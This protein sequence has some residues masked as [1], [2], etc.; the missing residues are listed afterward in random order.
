MT[1]DSGHEAGE[2]SRRGSR[3]SLAHKL[4]INSLSQGLRQVVQAVGGLAS[5]AIVSR[6]L[7][8]DEYGAVLAA[9]A[10]VSVFSLAG[11]FGIT[12]TTARL[13]AREPERRDELAT[14]SLYAWIAFAALAAGAI[15]GLAQVVYPGAERALI[16]HAAM[17]LVIPMA[18]TPLGGMA[19]AIAI[20]EQRAWLLAVGAVLSRVASLGAIV[21]A[22]SLGYGPIGI[23]AAFASGIA[24]DALFPF[25]L[26]RPRMPVRGSPRRIAATI[27]RL[28]GIAAPLG[29]IVVL[30]GLYF[31]LDALLLSLLGSTRD[32]AL[33]GVAYKGYDMLLV[34]PGFVMVTLLPVLA[35]LAPG[36][37][38]FR[39]IVQKAFAGMC[40]LVAPV[41]ALALLGREI[42]VALGGS[43]YAGGGLVL[44]LVL[45]GVLIACL[46][47]TLVQVMVA[48]GRQ[49][50]VLRVTA[51]TLCVNAIANVV[52]IPLWGVRGSAS[53]LLLSEAVSLAGTLL[54]YRT[55]APL[56]RVPAP[57]RLVAA[58]GCMAAAMSVRYV[59]SGGDGVRL[60]VGVAAGSVAYVAALVALRAVPPYVGDLVRGIAAAARGRV[61]S[62][63]GRPLR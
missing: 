35:R 25:L 11:D 5:V 8:I 32:V 58:V 63:R 18:L 29:A 10:F 27:R 47:G 2:A 28:V 13:M 62:P 56:P 57:A 46:N 1:T 38:R 20:V 61:R 44:A 24:F 17:V 52:A 15:A 19:G 12:V 49:R 36:D 60:L 30:N 4:A 33:Y 7:A 41:A 3:L 40:L 6:H 54:V 26:I 45:L 51:L 37:E 34:L 55:L 23:A 14:A 48:Q 50:V 9:M 53:A 22:A 16:R 42:M 43:Q 31:R 59:V 39:E 21:L